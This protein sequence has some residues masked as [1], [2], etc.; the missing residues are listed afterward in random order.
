MNSAGLGRIAGKAA[1]PIGL[2]GAIG[3]FISDVLAPLGDFAPAVAGISFLAAIVFGI[4][5]VRES[6]NN[7]H[8]IWDTAYSGGLF[9]SICS[10]L[11]FSIWSVILGA[12]PERGYLAENV[13]PIA[14]LQGQLLGIEEDIAEIQE[15]TTQTA[16][17]V[18]TI[19]T[20]QAQGNETAEDT[21]E[22]VNAM[23]TA[24]A[25]GFADIQAAFANLQQSETIVANPTTPQEFY[26][27]ARLHQ[28]RGNTAEAVAAYEGYLEFGLEYIDPVQD[29]AD[30]LK[31]T[32]G[33][34]RAREI[35]NSQLAE[36]PGSLVM[37][38]VAT[39]MLDTAEERL[40]RYEALASRAPDFGPAY[41]GITQAIDVQFSQGGGFRALNE[42]FLAAFTRLQELEADQN[43]TRYYIDKNR[44]V[45]L[46]DN[47][48]RRFEQA[49][50][51]ANSSTLLNTPEVYVTALNTGFTF[52]FIIADAVGE[53]FASFDDP[54]NMRG[55]GV[56]QSQIGNTANVTI[57]EVPLTI[58]DH[59]LYYK[60]VD[61]NGVESPVFEYPITVHPLVGTVNV[62]P[63][64]FTTGTST[65][66]IVV[67]AYM[68]EDT[69]QFNFFWGLS[70]DDVDNPSDIPV[71]SSLTT[72]SV[73]DLQ[74]GDYTLWVRA[75]GVDGE[76][77]GPVPFPFTVQ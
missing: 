1:G 32:E 14:Q 70:E 10:V 48:M 62:M 53:W 9:V 11:I 27:N 44:A 7:R 43:F 46:F 12:G 20:A 38:F 56:N 50:G 6:R 8:D 16:E 37:D 68:R 21:Q 5:T 72:V 39:S 15:T 30:L 23:A 51:A 19:A 2:I 47:A 28:L 18:Q 75:D 67:F 74:P 22:Q 29:Y 36:N 26:S 24:Q 61:Q 66:Q 58:G 33:I 57:N 49:Q 54:D 64:D 41:W 45:E 13:D 35:I 55:L 34:S 31:A 63:G 71:A 65:A 73:P 40:V 59:I 52:T 69:E 17:D 3:G 25:Q 77:L 4:M 76:V 60:Y 42:K